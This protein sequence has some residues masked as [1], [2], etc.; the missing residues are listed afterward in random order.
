MKTTI[1]IVAM[2]I[3]IMLLPLAMAGNRLEIWG[4]AS[5][6][7]A[8]MVTYYTGSEF[9]TVLYDGKTFYEVPIPSG[10]DDIK[11]TPFFLQPNDWTYF[12][13]LNPYVIGYFKGLWIFGGVERVATLDWKTF[14]V[15]SNP[16]CSTCQPIEFR[17]GRDRAALVMEKTTMMTFQILVWFNGTDFETTNLTADE[18]H[19][20]PI[21]NEWLVYTKT[22]NRTSLYLQQSGSKL[23]IECPSG[24]EVYSM[25]SNG[26]AVLIAT[27]RGL[28]VYRDGRNLSKISE[29]GASLAV[30]NGR[31]L[32]FEGSKIIE[33]DGRHLREVAQLN[34]TP[35][36]VAPFK[37][38]VLVAGSVGTRK[39]K[40]LMVSADGKVEDL[41]KEMT[42]PKPWTD[43]NEEEGRKICGP[44]LL[45]LL[46]VVFGM[47]GC[48]F[49]PR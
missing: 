42:S 11:K 10:R 23:S 4:L 21:G 46:T 36:Y 9:H 41:T 47:L 40:L 17:A 29:A 19:V 25:S 1:P 6:G 16:G 26:S 38:S 44:G 33:Y 45:A 20:A 22:G 35:T 34:I 2:L 43:R 5:N 13:R 27:N 31:W 14:R 32:V 24:L 37:G 18:I 8:A 39:W 7:T 48:R 28:Y 15:Y 3:G 12:D 30:W 49:T